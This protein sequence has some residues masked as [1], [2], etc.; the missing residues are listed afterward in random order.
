MSRYFYI[1]S[2]TQF[3]WEVMS[4]IKV[5]ISSEDSRELAA[6]VRTSSATTANTLHDSPAVAASIAAFNANKLVWSEIEFI[7]PTM[8][9]KV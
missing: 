3:I 7:V 8:L 2:S 9:F 1:M 6:S 5:S 4:L